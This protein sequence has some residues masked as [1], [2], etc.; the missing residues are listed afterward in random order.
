[1]SIHAGDPV[2]ASHHVWF[3]STYMSTVLGLPHAP[4]SPQS[5]GHVFPLMLFMFDPTA[6]Q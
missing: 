3:L 5:I 2:F 6:Q 1:M 4:D